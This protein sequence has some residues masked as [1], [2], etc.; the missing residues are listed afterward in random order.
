MQVKFIEFFSIDSIAWFQIYCS[1][2]ILCLFTGL[3]WDVIILLRI[4]LY[5]VAMN[6]IFYCIFYQIL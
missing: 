2:Q 4:L 5:K 1:L 3:L 6:S